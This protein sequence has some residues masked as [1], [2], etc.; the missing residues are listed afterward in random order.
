[1]ADVI[2]GKTVGDLL[3]EAGSSAV[4]YIRSNPLESAALATSTTPI[5]GDAL[6][7]LSDA[8]MYAT[9]PEE[10]NLLNYGLTA[11]GL[12]PFVPAASLVRKGKSNKLPEPKNKAEEKAKEV[13][14]LLQQG[15]ESEIT[16]DIIEKADP[17]YLA[18][19]YD[20]PMDTES[21]MKRAK[22]MGYDVD[23]VR[24]H[25]TDKSFDKFNPSEYQKGSRV[26]VFTT[27]NP[28]V[29]A[30]YA[31]PMRG[32]Q[33]YP[34]YTKDTYSGDLGPIEID[35]QKSNWNQLEGNLPAYA[36]ESGDETIDLYFPE[37]SELTSTGLPVTTNDIAYI[38][39]ESGR[40]SVT[41]TNLTDRGPQFVDS[42]LANW[43]SNVRSDFNP[44]SLRSIFARFDPRL[45]HLS[46]LSAGL[47]G[48]VVL[49]PAMLSG[50][51][52]TDEEM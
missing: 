29:A 15:R 2:Y 44:D 17:K 5:L 41:F 19:N 4:D 14:E 1:M 48:G 33:I 51:L 20:L 32:G 31:P 16:E 24:Y 22:E 10:R 6:G 12:I 40:P 27:D 18:D 13:L 26:G 43:P 36:S 23:N 34:V 47:A 50:L 25:G 8:K 38:A 28:Y 46:N 39:K 30:T 37:I 21:R 45:S 35:A 7:L 52:S 11:A 9:Q 49:T 3:G 42:P